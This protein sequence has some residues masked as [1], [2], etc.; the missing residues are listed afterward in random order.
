M[1]HLRGAFT[2]Y[3]SLC[4]HSNMAYVHAATSSGCLLPEGA[5]GISK[6]PPSYETIDV[7]MCACTCMYPL[8][9]LREHKRASLPEINIASSLVTRCSCQFWVM[10]LLSRSQWFDFHGYRP[11]WP[12][13]CT[14]LEGILH[15]WV[16]AKV[17]TD[18]HVCTMCGFGMCVCTYQGMCIQVC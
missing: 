6:F 13:L 7:H 9:C 18:V 1:V 10:C 3:T 15:S 5:A 4:Y 14:P 2:R 11:T 8:P 16:T 12:A 17:I